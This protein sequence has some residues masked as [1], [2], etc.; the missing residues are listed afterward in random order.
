MEYEAISFAINQIESE[1]E[2]ASNKAFIEDANKAQSALY[3]IMEKYKKE[4]DKA[5]EFQVVRKLVAVSKEGRCLKPRE[6]DALARKLLRKI[7]QK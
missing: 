4:R 7:R 2:A 3:N 6:I 5:S 1:V